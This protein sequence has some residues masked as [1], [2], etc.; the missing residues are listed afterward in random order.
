MTTPPLG[1]VCFPLNAPPWRSTNHGTRTSQDSEGFLMIGMKAL[2][3]EA[4]QDRCIRGPDPASL[5]PPPR[6]IDLCS[7]SAADAETPGG[8]V[9]DNLIPVFLVL[10]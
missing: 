4:A 9:E 1:S 10:S 2:F 3:R 8:L 5:L 7:S 6:R